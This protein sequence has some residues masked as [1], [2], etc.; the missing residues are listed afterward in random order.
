MCPLQCH[1]ER[2][3]Y[4]RTGGVAADPAQLDRP[5][6]DDVLAELY[7]LRTMTTSD[8]ILGLVT[9][10][11]DEFEAVPLDASIRRV[12][13]IGNLLGDTK[14]AIR[15]SWEL[16]PTA[17]SA[18][19]NGED[20]RL[21]MFDPSSWGSTSSPVEEVF[22]VYSAD[23]RMDNGMLAGHSVAELQLLL[24]KFG[25]EA[26]S[27][28]LGAQVASESLQ[29]RRV[30]LIIR[31]RAFA[32]LCYWERTLT[33]SNTN[34]RIFA[35]FQEGVDAYMSTAVPEVLV[36]FNAVFRR[37]RDAAMGEAIS[38]S[39]E[40]LS[41]AVTTCRR[42][43]KATADHVYPPTDD[44]SDKG[45]Q[46]DDQR[47]RN[48]IKEFVKASI[49][50]QSLQA[51]VEKTVEGLYERFV[52]LD[53]LASKGVHASLALS[54]AELCAIQTYIIAGELLQLADSLSAS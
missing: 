7:G 19:A 44:I 15:F 42:I 21:L 5:N 17:G 45:N 34:E 43:L 20:S 48:R 33:Y 35:R 22:E 53:G 47:Y 3:R 39:G 29:F 36:A 46:L 16:R 38:D 30:L 18:A 52:A 23:H 31:Q 14:T 26:V 11:L 13:R 28:S 25:D 32:R 1:R 8:H 41:Q 27:G 10:A 50:S 40:E 12:V 37:L 2:R 24:D 9:K 51:V 6:S 49:Q 54:D 4:S